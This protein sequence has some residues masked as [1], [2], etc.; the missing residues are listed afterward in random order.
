MTLGGIRIRRRLFVGLGLLVAASLGWY[1]WSKARQLPQISQ[2]YN[3]EPF[4]KLVA[5]DREGASR[6]LAEQAEFFDPTPLFIPTARNFGQGPLPARVLRQPGD[7]FNDIP[8]N[9]TFKERALANYAFGYQSEAASVPDILEQGNE[10]PFAGFGRVDGE[11]TII[12]QRVAY[13]AIKSI[14]TGQEVMG[15]ALPGL[16]LPGSEFAPVD[17]LAL[18][19]N[20]GFIGEPLMTSG[21]GSEEV[22][23]A[24][25]KYLV[26]NLRLGDRLAPG[27][28]VVSVGP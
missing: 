11:W 13:V 12:P 18:V 3:P 6:V 21:S 4:V 25:R 5:G 23:A 14:N 27:Q 10:A 19:G 26:Q 2:I 8:A 7:I 28:Y 15:Q 17:F 9:L 20:S 22:D 16:K 24:V 1:Y